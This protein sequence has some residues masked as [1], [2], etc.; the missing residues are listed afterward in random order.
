MINHPGWEHWVLTEQSQTFQKF[1]LLKMNC[2]FFNSCLPAVQPHHMMCS[3]YEELTFGAHPSAICEAWQSIPSRGPAEEDDV[4]SSW[5]FSTF[6]SYSALRPYIRPTIETTLPK[7]VACIRA[8]RLETA[9]ETLKRKWHLQQTWRGRRKAFRALCCPRRCQSQQWRERRWWSRGR[10]GRRPPSGLRHDHRRRC[11]EH[12]HE[13]GFHLGDLHAAVD[14]ILY[15]ELGQPAGASTLD[16]HCADHIPGNQ[17][18]EYQRWLL[19]HFISPPTDND[20]LYPDIGSYNKRI[21]WPGVLGLATKDR[22]ASERGGRR[23]PWGG[24]GWPR[25]TA[26]NDPSSAKTWTPEAVSWVSRFQPGDPD[27][28]GQLEDINR[29]ERLLGNGW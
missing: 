18:G 9:G 15:C 3:R 13:V 25:S 28:S 7:I 12:H 27:K 2:Y 11:Q 16:V 20:M 19:R 17:S 4:W 14:P 22:R 26:R 8:E 6:L 24:R 10:W 5:Y 23:R 21:V 29:G 1:R